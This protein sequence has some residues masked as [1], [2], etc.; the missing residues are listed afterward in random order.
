SINR[1]TPVKRLS[2]TD[3]LKS[4]PFIFKIFVEALSQKIN[5]FCHLQSFLTRGRKITKTVYYRLQFGPFG[6]S[7]W[8]MF[9]FFTNFIPRVLSRVNSYH[10]RLNQ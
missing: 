2:H 7:Y 10:V 8:V 9:H 3:T 4:P 1:I 5:F 6:R